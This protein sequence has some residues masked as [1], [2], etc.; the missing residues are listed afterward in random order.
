M[1][2]YMYYYVREQDFWGCPTHCCFPQFSVTPFAT[3]AF[4]QLRG[5]GRAPRRTWDAAPV[6][7]GGLEVAK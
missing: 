1:G 2:Y 4:C 6:E 7:V 5:A 3:P